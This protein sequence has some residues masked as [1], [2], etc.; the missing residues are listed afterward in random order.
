[1][2]IE[3]MYMYMALFPGPSPSLSMCHKSEVEKTE[4]LRVEDTH[5]HGRTHT[6]A[7]SHSNDGDWHPL[8]SDRLWHGPRAHW[9]RVLRRDTPAGG[10]GLSLSD[11]HSTD[12]GLSKTTCAENYQVSN[13]SCD[14]AMHLQKLMFLCTY[15]YINMM[16]CMLYMQVLHTFCTCVCG[17]GVRERER[18]RVYMYA[19]TP[20]GESSLL[21]STNQWLSW[22]YCAHVSHI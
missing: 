12:C 14:C 20:A 21:R 5:G 22:S 19:I 1:M 4:E 7:G 3:H 6:H 15:M 11:S 16:K 9:G 10:C 17:G 18:E 2:L 13:K 8:G